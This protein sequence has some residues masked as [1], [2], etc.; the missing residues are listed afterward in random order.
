MVAARV[1]EFEMLTMSCGVCPTTNGAETRAGG[2]D[3]NRNGRRAAELSRKRGRAGARPITSRER[4]AEAARRRRRK[5]NDGRTAAPAGKTA[6][7]SGR[8]DRERGGERVQR[9]RGASAGSGVRD[10][11]RLILRGENGKAA[12]ARAGG[13]NIDR[14]RRGAAERGRERRGSG[15]GIVAASE[16]SRKTSLRRRRELN[17]G[18][19]SCCRPPGC[20]RSSWTPP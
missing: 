13:G 10:R 14:C 18:R 11:H 8:D 4:S 5:L 2:R 3:I 7:A 20:F 12:K 19:S 1:P 15:S 16:C 9:E 17:T 6:P